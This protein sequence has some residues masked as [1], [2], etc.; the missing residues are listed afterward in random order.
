MTVALPWARSHAL[1][2]FEV[3]V[4]DRDTLKEPLCY[5]AWRMANPGVCV[6]DSV[7]AKQIPL[8]ICVCGGGGGGSTGGLVVGTPH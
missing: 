8:C 1:R 6:V 4:L 2:L 5:M 7:A 3:S